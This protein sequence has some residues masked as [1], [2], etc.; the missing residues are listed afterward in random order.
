MD[1]SL[2]NWLKNQITGLYG[3][4][5]QNQNQSGAQATFSHADNLFATS[6]N[7]T[8]DGETKSLDEYKNDISA[9][10]SAAASATVAWNNVVS[11]ASSTEEAPVSVSET[12]EFRR[13]IIWSLL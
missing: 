9:R 1:S 3:L 11:A 4:G 12:R 5:E 2:E 6:P 13:N 8:V 7:I 10:T